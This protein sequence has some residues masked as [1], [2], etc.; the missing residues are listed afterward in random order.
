VSEIEIGERGVAAEHVAYDLNLAS[1][2][3]CHAPAFCGMRP[4]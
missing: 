2:I 3:L 4:S 1:D